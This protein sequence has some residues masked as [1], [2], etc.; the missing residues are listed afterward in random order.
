M[1]GLGLP[2]RPLQTHKVIETSAAD[3]KPVLGHPIPHSLPQTQN[4]AAEAAVS[5]GPLVGSGP[6]ASTSE[7]GTVVSELSCGARAGPHV[8]LGGLCWTEAETW[9]CATEPDCYPHPQER[10]GCP[11]TLR[12]APVLGV[13]GTQRLWTMSGAQ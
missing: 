13:R 10:A 11:Q 9:A 2:H 12:G 8:L 5:S 6:C 3:P 1:L 4:A 7:P